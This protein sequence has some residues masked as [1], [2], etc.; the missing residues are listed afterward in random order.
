MFLFFTDDNM[1]NYQIKFITIL[2]KK[3]VGYIY[4]KIFNEK[5]NGDALSFISNISYIAI[6]TIVATIFSF[7]FNIIA[8][9]LGPSEYGKYTLVN[10]IAM[11]L[12][13]PMLLGTSTA[14]VKYNSEKIDFDRQK[15]IISTS[16]ILVFIFT[17]V[18]LFIYFVF[19]SKIIQVFSIPSDLYWLSVIF[20]AIFVWHTLAAETI[21]SLH[22]MKML[23][24]LTPIQAI[25]LLAFFLFF[26]FI[27]IVSFKAMVFSTY[28]SYTVTSVLICVYIHK[29]L[30][31]V[32]DRE[33]AR[34]LLRYS[35]LTIFSGISYMLYTNIDKVLINKYM[36]VTDV[37]IYNAYTYASINLF[38]IVSGIFITVFFPTISG[39]KNKKSI[40]K[41]I[42]K[43]IPY[44]FILGI[45]ST[46]IAEFII[47]SFYGK[48][49]PMNL[50]WMTTF[51]ITSVLSAWYRVCIW[52][53]NSEGEKG[54]KLTFS[55][56]GT[57]AII[58]ILLNIYLIP[59]WGLFGA[60]IAT[61]FAY[62]IGIYVV[63]SRKE[64]VLG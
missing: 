44:L 41:K 2:F 8:G 20:A 48:E 63:Y 55:G 42:N 62:C 40:L 3:N 56:T 61:A 64:T 53:F 37:G 60:I 49:Y 27:N 54:V 7:T 18:T 5:I 45:P 23:S 4:E 1:N 31:P 38:N 30:R 25:L 51:A 34:T 26:V 13:I 14:M 22:N 57:I 58:N 59:R 11:F 17:T 28:I 35:S 39:Y 10:T 36:T 46:I 52:L 19:R 47:L 15:T 33:W 32:F 12:Y 9:R 21:R 24:I 29:Y 16:Y 6:G 43:F 50:L